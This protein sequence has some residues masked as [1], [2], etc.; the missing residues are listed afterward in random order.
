VGYSGGTTAN[1][2]YTDLGDHTETTQLDFDPQRTSYAELLNL[3]WAAHDPTVK[4][5]SK[6]YMPV[7]FYHDADQKTLADQTR[8]AEA[9]KRGREIHTEIRPASTFYLAEDYH[10]KYF[11][12]GEASLFEEMEHHYPD[13]ADLVR[14]TAAARLNGYVGGYGTLAALQ[15]E[16]D[17]LGL[18]PAGRARLL[19]LVKG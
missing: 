2:T 19:S 11:L 7:I 5:S 15:A 16:I 6:Q 12:R 1:P 10:Q 4:C 14:S 3:F 18:T 13:A 9:Q 17:S 8:A